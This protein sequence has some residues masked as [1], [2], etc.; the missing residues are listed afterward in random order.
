MNKMKKR[1]NWLVN[2]SWKT[3]VVLKFLSTEIHFSEGGG[4]GGDKWFVVCKNNLTVFY[5]SRA[6]REAVLQRVVKSFIKKSRAKIRHV[7]LGTFCS[8]LDRP[9]LR[10]LLTCLWLCEFKCHVNFRETLLS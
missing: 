7:V 9:H 8:P 10:S 6:S 5:S 1:T 2:I 4:G 3:S